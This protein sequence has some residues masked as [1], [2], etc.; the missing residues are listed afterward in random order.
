MQKRPKLDE[1]D[2]GIIKC[3]HGD[4]RMAVTAIAD[5]LGLP[6]STVRHR[7]GRLVEARIIEFVAQTNPL[8]VGY[9][10]WIMMEIQAEASKIRTVAE[11]LAA[12]REVYIVYITTGGFDIS[13]GATFE[14][15]EAFV[16][17]L[18][19]PLSKVKGIVRVTTR[20][21]LEVYK[22]EFRFLPREEYDAADN[23]PSDP[24]ETSA[25]Q[26]IGRSRK[27]P[28]ASSKI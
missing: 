1:A 6:E 26:R 12:L 23:G 24:A 5:Q 15:N 10:V 20:A 14:D 27:K 19:G 3:L 18:A 28:R 22:R 8:R 25:V 11:Q 17:F 4:A 9:P 2:I 21:I 16:N 13:A 7:L